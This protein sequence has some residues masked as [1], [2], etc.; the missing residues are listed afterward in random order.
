MIYVFLNTTVTF[1][2]LISD[3]F[4]FEMKRSSLNENPNDWL[5]I[6]FPLQP[7]DC[8]WCQGQPFVLKQTHYHYYKSIV[9]ADD[10][11]WSDVFLRE[12]NFF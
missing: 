9:L 3:N 6:T 1:S 10:I 12:K 2:F 5:Q 8:L 4:S 7:C 11:G